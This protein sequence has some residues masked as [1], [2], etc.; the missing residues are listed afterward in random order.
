[1]FTELNRDLLDHFGMLPKGPGLN[2]NIT[3]PHYVCLVSEVFAFLS[4]FDHD[5]HPGDVITHI[6]DVEVDDLVMS[7]IYRFCERRQLPRKIAK[8]LLSNTARAEL[9]DES[10]WTRLD[11]LIHRRVWKLL[12]GARGDQVQ[13][14]LRR[15]L[16]RIEK[17]KNGRIHR[18]PLYDGKPVHINVSLTFGDAEQLPEEWEYRFVPCL[19]DTRRYLKELQI[20]ELLEAGCI[21]D[22]EYVH[23]MANLPRWVPCRSCW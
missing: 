16:R 1:M 2:I 14:T 18:H 21:T 9:S 12:E 7:E 20:K 4:A 3:G 8:Q 5:V 10:L 17:Y 11:A 22:Q 23:E 15:S 13:V 6:G 19:V